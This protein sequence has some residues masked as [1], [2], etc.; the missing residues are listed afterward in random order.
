MRPNRKLLPISTFIVLGIMTAHCKQPAAQIDH[1]A[2]QQELAGQ[3]VAAADQNQNLMEKANPDGTEVP[4]EEVLAI[5]AE[6]T[7]DEL[8]LLEMVDYANAIEFNADIATPLI[9]IETDIGAE[10]GGAL[11]LT[12]NRGKRVATRKSVEK[13]AAANK[14][15]QKREAA[16]AR[17]D[18]EK[19]MQKLPKSKYS[20]Q[21]SR[22]NESL[23]DKNKQ[24]NDFNVRIDQLTKEIQD[25]DASLNLLHQRADAEAKKEIAQLNKKVEKDRNSLKLYRK[26]LGRLVS[27]NERMKKKAKK[28]EEKLQEPASPFQ[29]K[30]NAKLQKLIDQT[31]IKLARIQQK[32]Y[33]LNSAI[34]GFHAINEFTTN[35]QPDA[36][37]TSPKMPAIVVAQD[38]N[39]SVR[40]FGKLTVTKVEGEVNGVLTRRYQMAYID[41]H[42]IKRVSSF[43]F[44][45][46]KN[47]SEIPDQQITESPEPGN[48]VFLP[49]KGPKWRKVGKDLY[50]VKAKIGNNPEQEI[51]V[52]LVGRATKRFSKWPAAATT[53]GYFGIVMGIYESGGDLQEQAKAIIAANNENNAAAEAN[54]TTAS[55]SIYDSVPPSF[56]EDPNSSKNQNTISNIP[57]PEVPPPPSED[58]SS[59]D[60]PPPPPSEDDEL[61]IKL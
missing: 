16:K 39:A 22:I 20:K 52:S 41:S 59:E 30:N 4:L 44:K 2:D 50:M 27:S 25:A 33:K 37:S 6:F 46:P 56:H 36:N 19:L 54:A 35:I 5:A 29:E 47:K 57:P 24:I 28:L 26:D 45:L 60:P 61:V 21:S 17:Q 23:K 8:F 31:R 10:E 3:Q 12:S 32:Y 49:T 9:D 1:R 15:N 58:E 34:S 48:P 7:E 11:S 38:A 55:K 13:S 51:L 18:L 42:N 40:E 53:L 43:D 14:A